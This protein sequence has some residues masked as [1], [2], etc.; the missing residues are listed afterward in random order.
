[1]VIELDE[2][3]MD[4]AIYFIEERTRF[5]LSI[6]ILT[7]LAILTIIG[8]HSK[9]A[10][11]NGIRMSI[12]I[13]ILPCITSIILAGICIYCQIQRTTINN[14]RTKLLCTYF[15]DGKIVTED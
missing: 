5:M 13:P 2:Q 6:Q 7:L 14:L 4:K 8:F 11:Y 15:K 10:Y 3:K 12:D 9:V 1:M